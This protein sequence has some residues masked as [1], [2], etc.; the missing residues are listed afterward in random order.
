MEG[1][2]HSRVEYLVGI[3]VY[4][5]VHNSPAVRDYW[6]HDGLYLA[7][8]ISEYIVQTRFKGVK[9][10]FHVSRPDQPKETPLVRRLWHNKVDVV[11]DQLRGCSQ[12]Y[13]VPPSHTAVDECMTRAT[14]R[15]PDT[16]KIPSKPIEQ[17]F[18]F[19]CLVDHGLHL[20]F[21]PNLEPGRARLCSHG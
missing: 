5:R 4:M 20:G 21:P 17:G 14:G 1:S 19:H 13:R 12:R 3:V 10:Y 8:P 6:R 15:S 7:H 16:Y 18:Q 11:S 9:W 2:F